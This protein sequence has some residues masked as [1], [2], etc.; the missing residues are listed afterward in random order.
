MKTTWLQPDTIDQEKKTFSRVEIQGRKVGK[1]QVHE[2]KTHILIS[3]IYML[4]NVI[5]INNIFYISDLDIDSKIQMLSI[6]H[7]KE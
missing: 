7:V 6:K 2:L 5:V 1:V 4:S 3:F